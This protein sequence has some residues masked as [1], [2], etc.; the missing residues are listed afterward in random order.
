MRR[1]VDTKFTRH[2]A[3]T[4]SRALRQAVAWHGLPRSNRRATVRHAAACAFGSL[5]SPRQL[6]PLNAPRRAACGQY[7][8]RVDHHRVLFTRHGQGFIRPG[9]ARPSVASNLPCARRCGCTG[10][11]AQRRIY[12]HRRCSSRFVRPW[13]LRVRARA[14]RDCIWRLAT[15]ADAPRSHHRRVACFPEENKQHAH[16]ASRY[17]HACG[18]GTRPSGCTTAVRDDTRKLRLH[19]ESLS[20]AIRAL[21]A[22][23]CGYAICCRC[24]GGSVA[25]QR[26]AYRLIC[27]TPPSAPIA[28]CAAPALACAHCEP[29]RRLL[30]V[31]HT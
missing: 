29:P 31:P 12:P 3:C 2:A 10:P 6:P 13:R 5:S 14:A 19:A 8:R 26:K 7:K 18:A 9:G 1:V 4:L 28:H 24:C 20:A 16:E 22:R 25:Q 27:A 15:A 11:S 21:F 17:A 30:S 23:R